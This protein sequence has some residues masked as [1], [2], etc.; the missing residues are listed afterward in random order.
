[1]RY[2]SYLYEYTNALAGFAVFPQLI[3]EQS[4]PMTLFLHIY[5]HI[6]VLGMLYAYN[7]SHLCRYKN[8][9]RNRVLVKVASENKNLIAFKL[10]FCS[11]VHQFT[12]LNWMRIEHING[13]VWMRVNCSL[14]MFINFWFYV[15]GNNLIFLTSEQGDRIHNK[16]IKL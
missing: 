6:K 9:L 3:Y 12:V 11:K 15:V 10:H 4:A 1:M 7:I 8:R 5:E 2:I 13:T 14:F 16:D